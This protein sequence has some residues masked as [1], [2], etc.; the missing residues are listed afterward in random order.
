[1]KR[2]ETTMIILLIMQLKKWVTE[3]NFNSFIGQKDTHSMNINDGEFF[4]CQ[5][6]AKRDVNCF[7]P[8]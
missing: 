4:Y 8:P 7:E 3:V 5:Y 1:M 6:E 2:V